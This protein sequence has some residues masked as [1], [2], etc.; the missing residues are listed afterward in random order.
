M[1]TVIDFNWQ[2]DGSH[3]VVLLIFFVFRK[4]L[5]LF[6]IKGGSEWQMCSHMSAHE[7]QCFT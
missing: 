2:A 6:L 1:L 3:Y 4:I 5:Q 7:K